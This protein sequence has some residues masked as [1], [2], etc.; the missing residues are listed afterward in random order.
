MHGEGRNVAMFRRIASDPETAKEKCDRIGQQD[1]AIWMDRLR[2][3]G[4]Y[5]RSEGKKQKNTT[6]EKLITQFLNEKKAKRS[7][8]RWD[9]CRRNLM[10]W[11]KWIGEVNPS[12]LNGVQL[13]A[14]ETYLRSEKLA[15][16]TARD[17]LE[18]VK[19]FYR[20]L[21]GI[22]VIDQLPRNMDKVSISIK[23]KKVQTLDIDKHI[24]PILAKANERE[25]LYLLLMLNCGMT[26]IDISKLTHD[27]V[28]FEKGIIT[29]KR[30]KTED[31]EN[32]P[33]VS[34][35]LWKETLSL[36]RKH[37]NKKTKLVLTNTNGGSLKT[38]GLNDQGKYKKA[39]NIATA[40]HRLC[41]R[42]PVT[43]DRKPLKL[44]RK[45][46]APILNNSKEYSQWGEMF[47]GHSPRSVAET[48]YYGETGKSFLEAVN[49]LGKQYG[50]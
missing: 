1:R 36:L 35:P 43:T 10:R 14:Y 48:Y 25:R 11:K 47:L 29:R 34:Y 46:S 6:L 42:E 23:K 49:W 17:A 39:D 19:E 18:A 37:R 45:T 31:Y 32:V 30:S 3:S 4:I 16:I 40:Y 21:W 15:D 12:T 28:D 13:S 9:N 5:H 20:W 50:F 38:D 27:E 33:T 8:G 41:K 24:K 44:I 7:L 26:Q 22:E 2:I